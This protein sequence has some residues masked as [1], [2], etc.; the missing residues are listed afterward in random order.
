[1]LAEAVV[2]IDIIS[3]RALF[4]GL[5]AVSGQDN[6]GLDWAARLLVD[7]NPLKFGLQ[8]LVALY[9]W[10]RPSDGYRADPVRAVRGA[11]GVILA[12]GL[13]R[14]AQT[15]LPPS[16]RPRVSLPDFPFPPLG[17]LDGLAD[18]SS[19]PSDTAALAFALTAVVWAAS[20]RLGILMAVWSVFI[21][22]LPRLYFGYHHMSD[23]VAGAVLGAGTVALALHAPLPS[24]V[25]ARVGH[26]FRLLDARAPTAVLLAF[27]VLG[28]ECTQAFGFTRTVLRSAG[29]VV[30][31]WSPTQQAEAGPSRPHEV[32]TEV[33]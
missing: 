7:V 24:Q 33:R 26:W 29:Q 19:M 16:P 15:L 5:N 10:L 14:A 23:L 2:N 32:M 12:M 17:G 27:F 22:C 6:P 28:T 20:R 13:G 9:I 21:T 1:M 11:M 3:L 18:W 30:Q 4:Y 25:I 8:T 31:A